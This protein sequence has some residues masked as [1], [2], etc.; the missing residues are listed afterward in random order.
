MDVSLEIALSEIKRLIKYVSEVKFTNHPNKSSVCLGV[1]GCVCV[2]LRM[3]VSV[4]ACACLCTSVFSF[5]CVYVRRFS[6][7]LRRVSVFAFF[8]RLCPSVFV[9]LCVCVRRF[10][11]FLA[12][13]CVGFRLS[14]RL[15]ASVCVC[16]CV[17]VRLCGASMRFCL[18]M[19]PRV[20]VAESSITF[21]CNYFF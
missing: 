8:L 17:C 19:W 4:S 11:S 15:C 14:S 2:C 9:F 10:S 13:V 21:P 6:P 7:F 18:C 16:L 3:Y 12:S 20:R 5:F 1:F